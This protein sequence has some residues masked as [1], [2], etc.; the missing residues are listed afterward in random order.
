L[1]K[2]EIEISV[3]KIKTGALHLVG[4][5]HVESEVDVE[6][7]VSARTLTQWLDA[8]TRDNDHVARSKGLN[9]RLRSWHTTTSTP[10]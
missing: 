3:K 6:L 1:L 5:S 4:G 2:R 9:G 7:G 10:M 8:V